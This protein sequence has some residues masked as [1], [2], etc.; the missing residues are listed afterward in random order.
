MIVIKR[1]FEKC[2]SKGKVGEDIVVQLLKDRGWVVYNHSTDDITHWLDLIAIKN[3]TNVIAIDIKTKS[4]LTYLEATGIDTNYVEE[5]KQFSKEHNMPFILIF[6]DEVT[7]TIYG[8]TLE[9]LEKPKIVGNK[10][11]PDLMPTQYGKI[12]KLWHLSSM[13]KIANLSDDDVKLL[14]ELSTR[15][16]DYP[17][18]KTTNIL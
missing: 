1:N 15:N 12:V 17:N 8:N 5:Y 14:K 11:Y 13:K 9:E 7:K 2:K 16:Y 6:V 18:K 4:R 10:E 3:K